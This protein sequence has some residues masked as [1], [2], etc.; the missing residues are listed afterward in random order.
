MN[1]NGSVT[2]GRKELVHTV[3]T[4][5]TVRVMMMPFLGFREALKRRREELA[6]MDAAC[7]KMRKRCRF[8]TTDLCA[9]VIAFTVILSGRLTGAIASWRP[10]AI[11]GGFFAMALAV[12]ILGRLDLRKAVELANRKYEAFKEARSGF[13]AS[14]RLFEL[15]IRERDSITFLWMG[16]GRVS[17]GYIR[18]GQLSVE[19]F[20]YEEIEEEAEGEPVLVIEDTKIRGAGNLQQKVTFISK[21]A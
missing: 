11:A 12:F 8:D 13:L 6:Q 20:R 1:T 10:L 21:L 16:D 4:V 9:A 5:P 19:D 2:P 3:V 18:E 15:L 14:A 7:A 17:I